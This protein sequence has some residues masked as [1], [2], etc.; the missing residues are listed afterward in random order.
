M[1]FCDFDGTISRQDVVDLMLDTFAEP[2]WREI[3]KEWDAGRITARE[4]LDRQMACLQV[5]EDDLANLLD[6]VEM[7]RGFLELAV[8]AQASGYPLIVFSDGFDWII[9]R[10]FAKHSIDVQKLGIR[11]IAS[12]LE[13]KAGA[14]R[15]GFPYSNNCSH[16][17][18]TCKPEIIHE[19]ANDST[20]VV[21]GDGRSDRF[22]VDFAEQVFA[23]GWLQGH[24]SRAG[25]PYHP[26]STLSDVLQ[27]LRTI[28][29]T[30][31]VRNIL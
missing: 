9:Q 2:Q 5:H 31:A 21:I 15:W 6:K 3:E 7:D 29:E 24:C 8:W 12:H 1:I 30:M 19:F 23:K 26:F 25:I 27:Q 11:I 14:P 10:L 16:G 13:F 17:C 20:V 4:C 22:A 18:G 28:N